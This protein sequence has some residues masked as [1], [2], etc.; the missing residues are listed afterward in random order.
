[1]KVTFWGTRGSIAAPLSATGVRGKVVEAVMAAAAAPAEADLTDRIQA[2]AFVDALPFTT[3]GTFGGNTSCV[4]VETGLADHFL[5]CDLG[6]GVR[7]MSLAALGRLGGRPG[8]FDI[9]LS[10]LH[11]D[12]IMGFPFFVP[13]YVP[14]MRVRVFGCHAELEEALRGQQSAPCFPVPFAALGAEISFHALEPGV[15]TEIAGFSVTPTPQHHG[16]DSYGYR[17]ERAGRTV[18][19]STDSEH[20]IEDLEDLERFAT[21]FREADVVIFD[22]MY[23]LADSVTV[24]QDWGHSS[25]VMGVELCHRA[26]ARRLVLFHHEPVNDDG[27][28]AALW[29]QTVRYETLTREAH[30]LEVIAGHDGLVLEL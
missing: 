5:V 28:L 19:Y 27:K 8:T 6:T 10:H 21:F 23:S 13:A 22:A 11:W 12:H 16:N 20:R 26:G 29:E 2:E 9:L 4:E 1:M 7:E 25:N 24:K 3:R 15:A 17:L 30:A 14:G 18:V